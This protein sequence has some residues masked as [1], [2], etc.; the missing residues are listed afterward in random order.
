[1]PITI[2]GAWLDTREKATV[3]IAKRELVIRG[4]DLK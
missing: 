4:V 1:M 2:E 3:Y